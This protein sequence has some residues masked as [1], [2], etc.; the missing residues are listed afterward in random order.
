MPRAAFTTVPKMTNSHRV[1]PLRTRSH[2]SHP[3][4]TAYVEVNSIVSKSG[5]YT[6]GARPN[7]S[8]LRDLAANINYTITCLR[9]ISIRRCKAP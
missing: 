8:V 5:C 9:F 6:Y 1:R 7:V 3:F 4:T 2:R